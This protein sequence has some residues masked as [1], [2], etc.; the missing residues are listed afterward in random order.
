MISNSL[1]VRIFAFVT[2]T[3]MEVIFKM[4]VFCLS[5][6]FTFLGGFFRI[7]YFGIKGIH[8]SRHRFFLREMRRR[9]QSSIWITRLCLFWGRDL[10]VRK[11]LL[12][13]ELRSRGRV[14]I[15]YLT[16][17]SSELCFQDMG[18]LLVKTSSSRQLLLRWF[19][20]LFLVVSYSL[21]QQGNKCFVF[22]NKRFTSGNQASRIF[23]YDGTFIYCLVFMYIKLITSFL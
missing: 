2:L 4:S 20:F 22:E 12:R 23:L 18:E 10:I 16:S 17:R 5:S 15:D 9:L 21:A 11:Y 1:F 8:E 14:G 7:L 6:T 3:I 13:F 19:S